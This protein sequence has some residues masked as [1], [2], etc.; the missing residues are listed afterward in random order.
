MKRY[1]LFTLLII[2]L[3][4]ACE[5]EVVFD[6]F[7][8]ET[9]LRQVGVTENDMQVFT[10]H[11]PGFIFEYLTRYT[12]RKYLYD[13]QNK[14]ER[15]EI[16]Q[17][18][19]PLSCAI[20]PGTDFEDGDDPRQAEIGQ[21]IEFEYS[22]TGSLSKKKSYYINDNVD[23]LVS[24]EVFQYEG[25]K[26]VRIDTYTPQ[27]QL[28]QYHTYQYDSMGNMQQEEYYLIQEADLAVL[29]SR[30]LS[31]FDTMHN[32]FMVFAVEGTPGI[33]T[34]KNNTTRKTFIYYF[35]GTEESYTQET[36]YEYN[37]LG[38]PISANA[39][40]YIYGEGE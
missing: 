35:S 14:L 39:I 13:D 26:I 37:D 1:Y 33:N 36:E 18:L 4:F 21:F 6:N 2:P 12:Y 30:T 40:E 29:Q 16:A 10:Y 31:E 9:L 20:I 28:T 17:S 22:G 15:V 25:D 8:S 5:K 27:G 19:N 11:S 23:Q 7:Q 38:Y 32:P 34:N 24:Y 3:L